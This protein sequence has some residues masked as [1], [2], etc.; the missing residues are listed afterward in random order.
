MTEDEVFTK[1]LTN[2]GDKNR[3]GMIT[4]SEWNDHYAAISANI[5]NDDHFC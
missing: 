2:F 5:D 3:D 1:F 4:R